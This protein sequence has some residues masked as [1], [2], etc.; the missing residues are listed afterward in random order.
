MKTDKHDISRVKP[1]YLLMMIR[2]SDRH[3][4]GDALLEVYV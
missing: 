3:T 1:Y 4:L 2:K